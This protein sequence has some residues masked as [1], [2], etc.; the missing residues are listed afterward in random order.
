ML[1]AER[2][3]DAWEA[4]LAATPEDVAVR[5]LQADVALKLASKFDR[6]RYG[7]TVRV[8]KTVSVGVD[9]ALLSTAAALLDRVRAPALPAPE[10][11]LNPLPVLI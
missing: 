4:A 9:A 1:A 11:E 3:V 2:A 7:E 6:A 8:E 5:K 10:R